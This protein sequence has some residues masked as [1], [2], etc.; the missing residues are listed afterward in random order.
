[1]TRR[2]KRLLVI[3]AIAAFIAILIGAEIWTVYG[4]Y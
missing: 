1:M 4:Y 3:L 2:Q